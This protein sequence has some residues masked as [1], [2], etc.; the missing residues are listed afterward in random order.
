ME[1]CL[2]DDDVP[3]HLDDFLGFQPLFFRCEKSFF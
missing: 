3:V 2:E 1:V